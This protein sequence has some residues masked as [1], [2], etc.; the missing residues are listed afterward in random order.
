MTACSDG[1]VKDGRVTCGSA[2]VAEGCETI[3]VGERIRGP[4]VSTYAECRRMEVLLAVV[5]AAAHDTEV[6]SFA[7]YTD[8]LHTINLINCRLEFLRSRDGH[9]ELDDKKVPCA[10][11]S[12]VCRAAALSKKLL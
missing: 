12:Q 4:K 5:G 6:T 9:V 10:W 3:S 1:G 8:S 2:L 11:C 7:L